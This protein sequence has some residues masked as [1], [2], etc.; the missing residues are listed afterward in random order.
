[1][2]RENVA[3]FKSSDPIRTT[4]A[5][6]VKVKTPLA[7]TTVPLAPENTTRKKEGIVTIESS[8]EFHFGSHLSENQGCDAAEQAAKQEAL[9]YATG[10]KLISVTEQSC[11]SDGNYEECQ[12]SHSMMATANG[13]GFIVDVRDRKKDV[14]Y[15]S[16]VCRIRITV[17]VDVADRDAYSN[18]LQF[19]ASLNQ[20]SFRH[21]E[22]LEVDVEAAEPLYL[23]IF[24]YTPHSKKVNRLFPNRFDDDAYVQKLMRLPSKKNAHRYQLQLRSEQD[25]PVQEF[26]FLVA[27]SKEEAFFDSYPILEFNQNLSRLRKHRLNLVSN[28]YTLYPK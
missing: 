19:R 17:D 9:E 5:N 21:G 13:L 10:V 20:S 11:S 26:I 6:T 22:L 28:T 4:T 2:F 7:E 3:E 8:G 1:M 12:A 16:F 23:Y 24:Q 14:D 18:S 15:T 25:Y 27:L